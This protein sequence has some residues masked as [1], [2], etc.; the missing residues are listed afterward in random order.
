MTGVSCSKCINFSGI[1]GVLSAHPYV[2][3]SFCQ[4]RIY[5]Q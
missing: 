3:V 4:T 5:G 1:N 2:C